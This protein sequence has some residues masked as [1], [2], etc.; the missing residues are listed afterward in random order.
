ML[1]FIGCQY[2]NRSLSRRRMSESLMVSA[3]YRYDNFITLVW[4]VACL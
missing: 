3:F 1:L 4:Q 2:L